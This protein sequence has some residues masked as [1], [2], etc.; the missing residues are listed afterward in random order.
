[1]QKTPCVAVD[2]AWIILPATWPTDPGPHNLNLYLQ[3]KARV[4]AAKVSDEMNEHLAA[5][6]DIVSADCHDWEPTS[7]PCINRNLRARKTSSVFRMEVDTGE[8]V[9]V[10]AV[11]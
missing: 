7:I 10:A 11:G 9:Q 5:E 1:M 6:F 2:T 8:C 3:L 4:V